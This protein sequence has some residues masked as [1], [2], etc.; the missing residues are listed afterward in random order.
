MNP[1]ISVVLLTTLTGLGQGLFT[2]TLLGHFAGATPRYLAL[3]SSLALLLTALGLVASFFHLGRPE[4]GWRA[5]SQWRTSWLSREVIALPLFMA[6]VALYWLGLES[7][8]PTTL[9]IGAVAFVVCIA[10]W[11]CTAMIYMCLKFIQEWASPLTMLNFVLISLASGTLVAVNVA[12]FSDWAIVYPL[13]YLSFFLTVVAG[14]G[15]GVSLIRN[16]RLK[17]KSTLQ[18]AIGIPNPKIV[19]RSMGATGGTFNTREF[20]HGKSLGFVKSVKWLAIM[21]TFVVPAALLAL[22]VLGA[23]AIFVLLAAIVQ[24]IGLLFER[25]FFFAQARHPQNLYYQFVS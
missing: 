21:L 19:Q 23:P 22:A 9:G 25:W 2:M 14:I 8:W 13:V 20:F 3:G 16:A 12:L 11:V 5:I 1:A 18:S 10:L 7:G 24:C 4:R 6:L 17:P 15:R